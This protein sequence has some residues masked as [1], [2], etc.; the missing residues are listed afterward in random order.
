MSTYVKE[1]LYFFSVGIEVKLENH[2][3]LLSRKKL[4][5][6]EMLSIPQVGNIAMLCVE[7]VDGFVADDG[8]IIVIISRST[9]MCH[10]NLKH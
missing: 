2:S 7:F 4:T 5:E 6:L 10:P 9:L 3:V 1:K 8:N